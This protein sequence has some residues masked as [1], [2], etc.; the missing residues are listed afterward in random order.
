MSEK[1]HKMYIAYRNASKYIR[2]GDMVE[3]GTGR[4]E[5]WDTVLS[6]E[7]NEMVVL[8]GVHHP[9]APGKQR[10]VYISSLVDELGVITIHRVNRQLRSA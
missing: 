6:V 9:T 3:D 10:R 2:P 7:G 8:N 1:V 5:T 4:R